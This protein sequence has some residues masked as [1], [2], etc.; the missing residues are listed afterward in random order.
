VTFLESSAGRADFISHGSGLLEQ[1]HSSREQDARPTSVQSQVDGLVAGFTQQ[2]SDWRSLVA[3]TAGGIAYRVGRVGVMAAG[4]GRFASVGIGLGAEVTAFEMTNRSLSSLTGEAHSHSNLWRWEGQGGIRQGLLNSLVTFGTIK[5]AGRLAQGENVIVQHLLQDTGMVFGQQ[6]SA[7]FGITDRPQG[8][9]AEQFLH[10]EATNLQLGAGMALAHNLAPALQGLEQGLDL[11]LRGMERGVRGNFMQPALATAGKAPA[12]DFEIYSPLVFMVKKS[13]EG[14][15][16]KDFSGSNLRQL[17]LEVR[18][19]NDPEAAEELARR[20]RRDPH[21]FFQSYEITRMLGVLFQ[22]RDPRIAAGLLEAMKKIIRG[23]YGVLDERHLSM[24]VKLSGQDSALTRTLNPMIDRL[25][26][27]R[28]ELVG[29]EVLREIRPEL[30]PT[31]VSDG[32]VLGIESEETESGLP[33][34]IPSLQKVRIT[35]ETIEMEGTLYWNDDRGQKVR[36]MPVRLPGRYSDST[37]DET[38]TPSFFVTKAWEDG[39]EEVLGRVRSR[40]PGA[41]RDLQRLL[42]QYIAEPE[43]SFGLHADTKLRRLDRLTESRELEIQNALLKIDLSWLIQE[44]EIAR[45]P[46]FALRSLAEQGHRGALSGL[47][48]LAN[49]GFKFA[50]LMLREIEMSRLVDATLQGDI[51]A[52]KDLIHFISLKSFTMDEANREAEG[53]LRMAEKAMVGENPTLADF[54]FAKLYNLSLSEHREAVFEG[55]HPYEGTL[56][57][58]LQ[59]LAL[60]SSLGF[61]ALRF[62]KEAVRLTSFE[63]LDVLIVAARRDPEAHDI[64]REIL[65]ETPHEELPEVIEVS[66]NITFTEETEIHIRMRKKKIRQRLIEVLKELLQQE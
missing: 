55:I 23:S 14:D 34:F 40:R 16:G 15:S 13:S 35:A 3:L 66:S 29:M 2:V 50:R 10:A 36:R 24:M 64:L 49:R 43:A 51:T 48:D 47:V 42:Q 7:S 53:L 33:S 30:V 11:S 6:V 52:E 54:A 46:R 25:R 1:N 22:P 8:S 5:G 27:L 58:S 20:A 45:R 39:F 60:N 28:P 9:L 12:A 19:K 65:R 44:S 18:E 32:R 37:S 56:F 61:G 26:D 4:A 21:Q 62:L 31:P 59:S 63:A 17:I 38:P 57:E 41:K